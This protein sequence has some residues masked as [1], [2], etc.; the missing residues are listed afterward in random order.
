MHDRPGGGAGAASLDPRPWLAWR[1]PPTAPFRLFCFPHAGAA[2]SMFR[3]WDAHLGPQIDVLTPQLPGRENRIAEPAFDE[4]EPLL[5]AVL[6]GLLAHLDRPFA[7]FGHSMGALVSYGLTRRLCTDDGPRPDVLFVSAYPAPHVEVDDEVV[8]L[9]DDDALVDRM[10]EY[11]GTPAAVMDDAELWRMLLPTIRAD[12]KLCETYRHTA[13]ALLPVDV[14][15][16][17]GRAD[18]EASPQ[19]MVR[20]HE[21]CSGNFTLHCVDGDHFFLRQSVEVVL[22]TVAARCLATF[23]G[24][25][26]DGREGS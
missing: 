2:A 10:R 19:S 3:A 13:P 22:A 24:G 4:L 12:F 23:A 7:L 25:S 1:T 15:A 18:E 9:L 17:A 6:A 21:L 26:T 8:H 16:F 14:V 20:W 11:A 5:D